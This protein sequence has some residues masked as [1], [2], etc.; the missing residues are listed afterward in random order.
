MTETLTLAF[1]D[2]LVRGGWAFPDRDHASAQ[3]RAYFG[4][5]VKSAFR[6]RSVRVTQRC[7]AVALWIPPGGADL[8]KEEE[9]QHVSLVEELVRDHAGVLLKGTELFEASHPRERPHFY[10]SLLG[11][12][13]DHRGKGLGMRLLRENLALIDAERMPAYLESTNPK[14]L[15]RYER[16]GFARIGA[17]TLP[18]GGPRVDTMWREAIDPKPSAP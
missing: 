16:L 8:T 7:E 18:G 9:R 12:H 11:T 6:Y 3:R 13:Y 5:F 4:L 10:L 1:A 14:N 15:F 17:F 2:D